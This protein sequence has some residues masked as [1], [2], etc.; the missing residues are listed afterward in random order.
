[1]AISPDLLHKVSTEEDLPELDLSWLQ[2]R[3]AQQVERVRAGRRGMTFDEVERGREVADHVSAFTLRPRDVRPRDDA[4]VFELVV[5][6]DELG[7]VIG[8]Q[9]RTAKAM[10]TCLPRSSNISNSRSD[11]PSRIL[12]WSRNPGAQCT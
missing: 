10:R 3:E 6:Q 9:G 12:G 8:R 11:A 7:K 5:A 1:M 2:P 4:I